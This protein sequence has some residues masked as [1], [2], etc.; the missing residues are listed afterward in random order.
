MEGRAGGCSLMRIPALGDKRTW[1][2][3]DIPLNGVNVRFMAAEFAS[4]LSNVVFLRLFLR[5][6]TRRGS[7]D[8]DVTNDG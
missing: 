7:C 3:A 1:R 5:L 8:G 2:R 6:E 4:Y